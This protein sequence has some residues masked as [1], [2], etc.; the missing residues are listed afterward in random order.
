MVYSLLGFFRLVS[1]KALLG[2]S[3][4]YSLAYYRSTLRSDRTLTASQLEGS[5]NDHKALLS[6]L[7]D[8]VCDRG[9]PPQPKDSRVSNPSYFEHYSL[10][11]A[12]SLMRLMRILG[13]AS[14]KAGSSG[15]PTQ[16]GTRIAPFLLRYMRCTSN[17]NIFQTCV[18][19]F[20]PICTTHR[21]RF[22]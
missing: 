3:V 15:T 11:K 6:F 5:V 1:L 4:T 14:L 20:R 21:W 19:I 22:I 17:I 13:S 9:L 2:A 7:Q 12:L 18:P 10:I 8:A 16:I